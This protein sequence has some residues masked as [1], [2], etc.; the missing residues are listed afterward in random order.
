MTEENSINIEQKRP[1]R[2]SKFPLTFYT[3]KETISR[4][5]AEAGNRSM[6]VSGFVNMI[7]F[8]WLHEHEKKPE[9]KKP[10][11][12]LQGIPIKP[13]EKPWEHIRDFEREKRLY[14]HIPCRKDD[15]T[16][17]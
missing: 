4:L 13:E 14:G 9:A 1:H 5:K 16:K 17:E 11:F 8:D 10:I 12:T 2:Q 3:S 15:D 6:S 7:L